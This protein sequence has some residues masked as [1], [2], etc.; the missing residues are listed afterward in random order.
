MPSR[1]AFLKNAAAVAFVAGVSST[2]AALAADPKAMP[3]PKPTASPPPSVLARSLAASLQRDLPKAHL[4][5]AMTEK[6]ARDIDGNSTITKAF[7]KRSRKNLPE[8][9]CAFSASQPGEQP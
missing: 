7:R 1:L 8:P 2:G 6:I 9:V 4:S 3:S 5:D